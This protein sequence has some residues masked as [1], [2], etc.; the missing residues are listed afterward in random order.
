MTLPDIAGWRMFDLEQPRTAGAPIHPGHRV[1]GYAY[2]LHRRH[3][4]G[5]GRTGA[6]GLVMTSDHA[7]THID[8]LC[9]QALDMRLHGDRQ[10]DTLMTEFGFRDMG[11]ETLPPILSRG[12]LIDLARHRGSPVEPDRWV[13]LD[14]VRE[15]ARTQ[16]VEPGAGDVVL[17]RTGNGA[18]WE[19]PA[20]YLRGSGMLG[21]VST[22]LAEVGVRAVGADNVAWDS[23]SGPDP[24]LGMALPGHVI[25]LI[26]NGV[27]IIENLNLEELAEAGH[28]EFVFVCLPL[29]L[30]GATGSPVRP[31]ALVTA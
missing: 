8:A 10:A 18:H 5:Q 13:S 9:H 7:G 25:L 26:Q 19:D 12:V 22:W 29:K 24:Q 3:Q 28:H 31:V 2:L 16:G 4:P 20:R 30:V 17:V 14:E 15:A 27:P 1:P 21:E 23:P 6:S 11:I